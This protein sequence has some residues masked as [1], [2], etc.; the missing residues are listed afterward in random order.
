MGCG[1]S[2]TAVSAFDQN[3]LHWKK[4]HGCRLTTREKKVFEVLKGNF[5]TD[6]SSDMKIIRIFTSST[7]TDTKHERDALMEK[8]YPK[9]KTYCQS[10]G[11]EFQ[12]VDMRWGIR[13]EAADD[14]MTTELCLREI[15]A[16]QKLSTGPNFVTL[17]SHKYGQ[18]PLLRTIDVN[19]FNTIVDGIAEEETK[20]L[21][22][23]WYLKDEN[24]KPSMYVLQPISV[25]IPNFTSP[26]EELRKMAKA[27]WKETQSRLQVA[28]TDS[29]KVKLRDEEAVYKYI[30]SVTASEIE[31]GLF[32]VSDPGR[33]CLWFHRILK[34]ID[35]APPDFIDVKQSSDEDVSNLLDTLKKERIPSALP[36]EN[37]TSYTVRC[38]NTNGFDPSMLE[39]SQYLDRLCTDFQNKLQQKVEDAI[40]ERAMTDVNDD[41]FG[42]VLQHAKFCEE[43]CEMFH[44]QTEALH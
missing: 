21:V 29:A 38:S 7:F 39:N 3:T 32:E 11:Y 33:S 22:L 16:C 28:L 6:Y 12:V 41:V 27:E 9:L 23:K 26:D 35:S 42:E 20:K 36:L 18:R 40:K 31:K 43:K 1:A 5:K 34:P 13:D 30:R 4:A 10:R 14:H 8:A 19:E 15:E 2:G 37:I 24:Y 25:A 17:L 44:G